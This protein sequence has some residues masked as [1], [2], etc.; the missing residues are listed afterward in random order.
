MMLLGAGVLLAAGVWAW[1]RQRTASQPEM[2]LHGNVEVRGVD[3]GFRV[4]GRVAEVLKQEGDPVTAG[5][6]LARLDAE[7]F[8]HELDL[9][10]AEEAAAKT[11][12]EKRTRGYR[13]EEISQAEAQLEQARV[14][15]NHARLASERQKS[16]IDGGGTSKQ[17]L[18]DSAAAEA[19]AQQAV[20]VAEA[21]L[22]LLK[23]G[24]RN[25]EIEAARQQFLLAGAARAA[26][27]LRLRDT[28]LIAA[29]DGTVLT[30][31][32]EP[33]SI[34][35]PGATVLGISLNAPVWVRAYAAEPWLPRLAPGTEVT[36]HADG[37]TRSY[38]G[39]VGFV[40]PKAEFTPKSVETPE[41][42]T[43]LV[44]RFRV[45]VSDPDSQLRQ[46]MPVTI[47]K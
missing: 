16:L 12:W 33:G 42:R 34:V 9:R 3:W 47:T 6:C 19:N 4:G 7:P 5:D 27:E 20:R 36:V 1:S 29:S 17:M 23:A 40:S 10:R 11:E 43:M 41:L 46:G 24:F 15:H 2:V 39:T 30:R 35:Q 44:Y 18:E 8:R 25:E 38:H 45:V 28:E 13:T 32:V 26:A 37:A 22:H 31:A 14:A 21:K